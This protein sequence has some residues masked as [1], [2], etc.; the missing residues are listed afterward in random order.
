MPLTL[1]LNGTSRTFDRLSDTATLNEVVAELGLQADRV[2]V[3]WN[4]EIVARTAWP[5]SVVS[6]GDKLEIVHFV[7][8]GAL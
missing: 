7:G 5:A 2:A 8:G 6:A 4:G 1:L 3:E